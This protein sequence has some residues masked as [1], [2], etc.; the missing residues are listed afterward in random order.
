M[1]PS[2]TRQPHIQNVIVLWDGTDQAPGGKYLATEE[3]PPQPRPSRKALI[4]SVPGERASR[5]EQA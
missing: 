5:Q 2:L 3:Q 1:D 4:V